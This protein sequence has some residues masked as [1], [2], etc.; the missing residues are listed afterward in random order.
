[1]KAFVALAA[2]S[3]LALLSTAALAGPRDVGAKE[4]AALLYE[5]RGRENFVL[6]DIRT[7]GEFADERIA[8]AVLIDYY[9][10]TF[11]E[12]LSK[13]DRSKTY[14]VYCRTGNRSGKA[15]ALFEEL[16]FRKVV[17]LAR[18]ITEWKAAGLPTTRGGG[19]T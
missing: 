18:G 17:H 15:M 4:G 8:G 6:L 16:G 19:A 1:M 5:N 14:F 12:E 10:P 11:R 9:A 7:P 2:A 13:L 3:V